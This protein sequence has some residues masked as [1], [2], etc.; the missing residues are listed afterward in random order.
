M[1]RHAA[2]APILATSNTYTDKEEKEESTTK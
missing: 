2:I 1:V